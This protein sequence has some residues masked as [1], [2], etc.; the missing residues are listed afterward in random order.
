MLDGSR[1]SPFSLLSQG[2]CDVTMAGK[3]KSEEL[4]SLLEALSAANN[5]LGIC[6]QSI[7]DSRKKLGKSVQCQTYLN[8]SLKPM[9]TG[10]VLPEKKRSLAEKSDN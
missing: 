3:L 5:S 10:F 4:Q 2:C 8:M 6:L 7:E 9:Q 1:C